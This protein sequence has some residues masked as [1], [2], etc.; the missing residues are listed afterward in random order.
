MAYQSTIPAASDQLSV[1]QGDIQNNFIALSTYLN[2]NHVDFNGADQGKHKFIT[3]PVQLGAPAINAGELGLYSILNTYTT[4]NELNFINA[5]GTSIPFTA[6]G[7]GFFYL[8]S[9]LLIKYGSFTSA[10]AGSAAYS[11]AVSANIPVFASVIY[12]SVSR[13]SVNDVYT[14]AAST[15]TITVTSSAA[16]TFNYFVIGT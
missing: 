5:A 16:G 1:S 6:R 7:T 10:G 13:T 12:R 8:P 9:G 11:F 4:A 2:V 14:T 15:T 3:F